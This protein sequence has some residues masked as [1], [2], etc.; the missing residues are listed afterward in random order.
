[1]K[2]VA[3]AASRYLGAEVH[4]A[5]LRKHGLSEPA[6]GLLGEL[7]DQFDAAGMPLD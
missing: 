6:L 3:I 5:V 4:K 7:L 2:C 1:M